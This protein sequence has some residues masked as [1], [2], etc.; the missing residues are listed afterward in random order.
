MARYT[1]IRVSSVLG[2]SQLLDGGAMFGNAPRPLW[3]GWAQAG[4]MGRMGLAWWR[5][6]RDGG[7]SQGG[8]R[9]GVG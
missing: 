8:C 7:G 2:N 6:R 5:W 1:D 4:A 9:A 3:E